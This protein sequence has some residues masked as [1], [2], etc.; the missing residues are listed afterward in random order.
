[1][2][3][4]DFIEKQKKV[5]QK[6][7]DAVKEKTGKKPCPGQEKAL[8]KGFRHWGRDSKALGENQGSSED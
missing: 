5:D 7:L 2:S 6:L 3:V 1:M 4:E 8:G